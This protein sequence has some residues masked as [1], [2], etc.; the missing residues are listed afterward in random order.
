[1]TQP[2]RMRPAAIIAST[3]SNVARTLSKLGI[4]FSSVSGR[5][6]T[7]LSPACLNSVETTLSALAVET[8]KDTSVGG[9]SMFSNVPDMESLPPIEPQDSS[10]CALNAPSR[11]AMGLPQRLGSFWV[12]SKYSWNV[13]QQWCQLPPAA[14]TLA[15][16]VMTASM[17]P[18]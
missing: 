10:S 17:A 13:S 11:A 12:R 16:E 3:L 6:I 18:R 1:M 2:A 15:M 8:A 14:T 7:T 9:T 4:P 5:S